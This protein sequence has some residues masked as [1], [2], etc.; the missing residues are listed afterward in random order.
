MPLKPALVVQRLA[1]G[2]AIEPS[3]QRAALAEIANAA[4]GLQENFL[5][6]ISRV[7]SVAQHAED[8]VVDR[9]MIVGAEPVECRLRA[10]LQ[11]VDEF[12]FIVAPK[13]GTSPI[14]HCRP[15]RPVV[16]QHRNSWMLIRATL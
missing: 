3:L 9:R 16:S 10:S 12:G 4:K 7:R 2:D 13:K 6:A 11:L 1:N 14:G 8:E 15:F 5:G